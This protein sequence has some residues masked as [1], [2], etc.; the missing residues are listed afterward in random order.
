MQNYENIEEINGKLETY[1]KISGKYFFIPNE[2]QMGTS[3]PSMITT[4]ED[5]HFLRL[6]KQA[7]SEHS[8]KVHFKLDKQSMTFKPDSGF[9]VWFDEVD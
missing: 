9:E 7:I 5:A 8:E 1:W 6:A 3:N 2:W 4:L